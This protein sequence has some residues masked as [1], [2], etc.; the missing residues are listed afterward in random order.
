MLVN[1]GLGD[2]G[3][4]GGEGGGGDGGGEGGGKGGGEGGGGDGEGGRGQRGGAPGRAVFAVRAEPQWLTSEPTPRVRREAERVTAPTH[5]FS[6]TQAG[7]HGEARVAR[8]GARVAR[9]A[10]RGGGG[11]RPR[12]GAHVFG[13]PWYQYAP[14]L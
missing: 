14:L 3:E 12:S 7:R 5:V 13:Q 8:P 10:A 1:V 11:T 4:G 9:G 2:G 6:H